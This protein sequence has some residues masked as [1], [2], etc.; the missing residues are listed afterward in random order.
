MALGGR[1][2]VNLTPTVSH[3]VALDGAD[4]DI[5]YAEPLTCCGWIPRPC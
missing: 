3:L 1:V 4:T 5:R 2:A